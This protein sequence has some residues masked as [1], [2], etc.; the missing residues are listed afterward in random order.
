MIY[1]RGNINTY[2]KNQDAKF[3]FFWGHQPSKNDL[4][5]KG[6]LSQ[7]YPKSFLEN[8]IEYLT[9]EHY[10]MIHKARLFNDTEIEHKIFSSI[11]PKD[12]KKLGR[13]IKTFDFNT[14]N[15]HKYNIVRQGNYL[16]FSQNEDLKQFLINTNDAVLVEASPYDYVWGIG[17]D[18]HN[19]L[20]IS[21]DHWRGENLLGFALM[22]VR[23]MIKN[24]G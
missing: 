10:M 8:G 12:V 16:K 6:C 22:E 9:A 18:E 14:W 17:L 2:I 7:W 3:L 19:D 5:S 21:P 4:I 15:L 11:S 23:D 20:A 13:K 1:N 24:K